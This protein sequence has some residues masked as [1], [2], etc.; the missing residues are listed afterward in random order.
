[1]NILMLCPQFPDTFWSFRYALRFVGKKANFPPLGL[2]TVAGLLPAHWNIRLVDMNTRKLHDRDLAWADYAFIT[3]MVIQKK[4]ACEVIAR[5]KAAGLKVVAGGPLFTMEHEEFEDVDHFI[6]NEAEITL[7][8]FLN[9]L[10]NNC[11]KCV[12]KTDKFADLTKSSPPAWDLIDLKCYQGMEIQYSRGCPFNCEFCNVTSLFGRRVRTK[13]AEQI[14]TELETLYSSGWRRGNVFFVDDNFIGNKHKLKTELLPHLIE[15]RKNRPGITFMTEAS[16]NLADD[17]EL[18]ALMVEAGFNAVFIGIETPEEAGLAECNKR[19]NEHRDMVKDVKKIQRA[20]LQVQGGFIVGFDSDKLSIFQRQIE[21]IQNSGIVIA[22][23]GLLQAPP[24]TPL[25]E[26]M[27]KASR[28]RGASSGDNVEGTTN[29]VPLMGF[30]LLHKGYQNILNYIYSPR[31][32][33]ERIKTMFSEYRPPKIHGLPSRSEILALLRSIYRQGIL[34]RERVYYW[35]LL[36][37]TLFKCPRL[38]PAAVTL[39]IEGYHCRKV[40]ELHVR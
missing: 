24:G 12:Y 40:C 25:Y 15:W 5:C 39:A 34:S 7:P 19:Q 2:L 14:I 17:E 21:F 6:L 20:G 22:M 13:N 37:W 30:D 10:E 32:Y 18:M 4:S 9:D 33:Y 29:I 16:I 35:K 27:K 1:M 3:G 38:L 36:L 23:V 31:N 11:P 28:L 8:E 26:R